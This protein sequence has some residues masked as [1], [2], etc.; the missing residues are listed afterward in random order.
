MPDPYTEDDKQ[1]LSLVPYFQGLD[2]RVLQVIE[3]DSIRRTYEPGRMV[4]L[5]GDSH[6]SHQ[7]SRG[8]VHPVTY[9]SN[10]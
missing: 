3:Q 1:V 10:F 6:I 2:Q 4:N 8:I 9:H 5:E 7:Q